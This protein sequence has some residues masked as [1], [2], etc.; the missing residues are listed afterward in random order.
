MSLT[1][2][3]DYREEKDYLDFTL[4]YLNKYHDYILK[5]KERIDR[6]VDYNSK[7]L[8]SDSSQ[9]FIDLMINTTFQGSMAKKLEDIENAHSKPYFSRVDFKEDGSKSYEKIYIGKMSL[10]DDSRKSLIVVDWRAP[11]SNLYYEGRLGPAEYLCPEGVIEGEIFLKRQYTIENGILNSF[12]DID[13]TTSDEFLQAYLGANADNRLKDIVSTIQVEQNRIIRADMWKPLIV[14]G[15]A[16]GGKTTIALHRIAYLIYTYE[17]TFKPEN[18]MIIAPNRLFLNYISEV[19]PEL[20]VD[21]V[22]QITFEDFASELLEMK[23]KLTDPNEKLSRLVNVNS[24]EK[25]RN[26]NA[27][28]RRASEFKASLRFKDLMDSYLH[29]IEVELIPKEHFKIVGFILLKYEE[30]QRLFLEEYHDLPMMKRV[31]EI[32][33]HLTNR[34]KLKKDTIVANLQD[35]CDKRIKELKLTM[36]ESSER[37][38]LIV[39]AIDYKN[40]MIQN[41]NTHSKMAV[42]EYISKITPLKPMQYYKNLFEEELFMQLSKEYMDEELAHFIIDRA[43]ELLGA[44]TLEIEDLAPLTSIKY[45]VYGLNEKMQ[46]KHIVID[47]AQD[48]SLYQFYVLKKIIRDSSFTILGDLSQGIHGY[49]GLKDWGDITK[50]VFEGSSKF[51]TLEQSYRTTV[52]IM[53]AANKVIGSLE[54]PKLVPAKPV[55]RHGEKAQVFERDS[56]KV[57]ASEIKERLDNLETEGFKS[58]AII[59]KTMDEC[60]KLKTLL[61]GLKKELPV[62]TGNEKEYTGG[63]VIVPSYLSKG[64]EFDVVIISNASREVYTPE[65]LDVKLLY[66]AMTRPLHRLYIY[67]LGEPS[68]LLRDV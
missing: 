49:R 37:H 26:L 12:F 27:L 65:E 31:N 53:E 6:E 1:Q 25:D 14:Q 55:I 2:H 48:F 63:I 59:C 20:G 64:L 17:K 34:L 35:N 57:I 62:I 23:L 30:I 10:M 58:A 11:I 61:K 44:N 36:E 7:H 56:L 68:V 38:R 3:P 29:Q 54:D 33:K 42:K 50:Y 60:M 21:R 8:S 4:E 19:L 18:F 66:V 15:A 40:D 51:L 5:E 24:S 16:G 46:V 32:K 45:L 13:I 39:E 52:E 43:N 47:E 28:I 41:I 67:S 22:K 9:Q